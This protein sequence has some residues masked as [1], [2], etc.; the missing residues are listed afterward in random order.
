M[1]PKMHPYMQKQLKEAEKTESSS[2]AK[3][4]MLSERLESSSHTTY[5]SKA[6]R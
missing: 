1:P 6:S 3:K 4:S 5:S 2:S